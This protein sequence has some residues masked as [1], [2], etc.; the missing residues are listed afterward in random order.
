[1]SEFL[2]LK[3]M[4][5]SLETERLGFIKQITDMQGQMK[6]LLQD[7]NRR[8]IYYIPQ[9]VPLS[10]DIN[11]DTLSM[12]RL[13]NIANEERPDYKLAE[14]NVKYEETNL[15]LQ[16]SLAVPDLTIGG[17]Y[18][19]NGSYIPDYYAI[20]FG[21]DIP[22]FNRNQGNIQVS[23]KN[24]ELNK[25]ILENTK[26]AIANEIAAAY[27]KAYENDKLYKSF[28]KKFPEEY[29]SLLQSMLV[30]YE[31]RNMTII[32]FTDF[33][34]SYRTSMLQLNQ[35]QNDRLDA[36]EELNYI[37]GKTIINQ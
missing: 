10:D 11:L 27:R 37:V 30:N 18:S 34:E 24:I 19:R 6:L 4:L 14:A 13:L 2:R 1:M 9:F 25:A 16:K 29:N 20:T 3:A 33:F 5:F 22:I 23:E 31:K 12:D 36:I 28:D 17:R 35:L 15:E 32:E 7:T 21:I 8:D 26:Q